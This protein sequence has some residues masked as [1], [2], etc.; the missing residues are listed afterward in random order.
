MR[1]QFIFCVETDEKCMSDKMYIKDTI[2]R[3]FEYDEAMVKFSYVF[4]R[5][6]GK[7]NSKRVLDNIQK[8]VKEF[9]IND[10]N[11]RKKKDS[12][13]HEKSCSVIIYCFDC[14]DYD[15]DPEPRKFLE[16]VSQYCHDNKYEFVWFCKDIERVYIGEKIPKSMKKKRAERFMRKNKIK[17]L[18]KERLTADRYGENRSNLLRVLSQYEELYLRE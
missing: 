14:D 2:K 5:G 13:D 11:S 8:Y 17:K 7:Y 1:I 18:H 9:S 15:I 4:M 16:D 3:F 10:T 12:S 6:K